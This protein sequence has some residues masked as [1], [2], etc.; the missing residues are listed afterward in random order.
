MVSTSSIALSFHYLDPDCAVP[1]TVKFT[2]HYPLPGA[3]Y[4]LAVRN[5]KRLTGAE[6][7]GFDM[8]KD[9]IDGD[10][11]AWNM[12]ERYNKQ[13][14]VLLEKVYLHLR[15]WIRNHPNLNIYSQEPFK[16]PNCDSTNVQKRGFLYNITSKRQRYC[17]NKC[18]AWSSALV[19][20]NG[21]KVLR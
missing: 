15:P 14:V 9:C 10:K 16:C 3:Q 19:K 17:C 20:K 11:K 5:N 4:Q 6:H 12:M 18:G 8:W 2:E 21:E 1:G 7:T 13:D